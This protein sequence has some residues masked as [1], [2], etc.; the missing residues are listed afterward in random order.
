MNLVESISMYSSN[1]YWID[2]TYSKSHSSIIKQT[3]ID[4]NH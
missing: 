4:T 2:T 1:G 3:N